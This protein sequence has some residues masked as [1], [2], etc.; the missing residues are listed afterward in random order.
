MVQIPDSTHL[1]IGSTLL[2]HGGAIELHRAVVHS[3]Q[4]QVITVGFMH[5]RVTQTILLPSNASILALISHI[6]AP[7]GGRLSDI[8]LW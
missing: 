6:R 1:T 5:S 4:S 2:G 7:D 8:M 3:R